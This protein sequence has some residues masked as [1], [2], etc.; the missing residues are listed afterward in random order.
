VAEPEGATDSI[1]RDGDDAR[2]VSPILVDAPSVSVTVTA[3]QQRIVV[4]LPLMNM[5]PAAGAEAVDDEVGSDSA[6]G[7]PGPLL[8][9]A[10]RRV[11]QPPR[12]RNMS[13]YRGARRVVRPA[14]A[15]V[16]G[17]SDTA[18][19]APGLFGLRSTGLGLS[20]G[21]A[22]V[23]VGTDGSDDD[24]HVPAARDDDGADFAEAAVEPTDKRANMPAGSGNALSDTEGSAFGPRSG[25]S[26]QRLRPASADLRRGRSRRP[27]RESPAATVSVAD[28]YSQFLES[29]RKVNEE[30]E[31]MRKAMEAATLHQAPKVRRTVRRRR[32]KKKVLLSEARAGQALRKPR[33]SFR[34]RAM[35]HESDGVASV[36]TASSH[37]PP[38]SP[39]TGALG[40]HSTRHSRSE[41]LPGTTG[42]DSD[43]QADEDD[44]DSA[45]GVDAGGPADAIDEDAEAEGAHKSVDNRDGGDDDVDACCEEDEENDESGTKQRDESYDVRSSIASSGRLRS[46][47]S[48]K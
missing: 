37:S 29:A 17:R 34:K 1:A 43:T 9:L 30:L 35:S 6:D 23:M 36:T 5:A 14:S 47:S 33:R 25:L 4:N 48:R 19:A 8:E 2:S 44:E 32:K 18:K 42:D 45:G 3:T 38:S 46:G 15:P 10:A 26:S 7:Q 39:Q 27:R 20:A 11:Y 40:T 13:G 22:P 21:L 41:L 28:H 31:T 24:I 16:H 12:A